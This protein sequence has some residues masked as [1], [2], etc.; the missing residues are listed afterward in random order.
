MSLVHDR[1]LD[2]LRSSP[3][4][5][6]HTRAKYVYRKLEHIAALKIQLSQYSFKK[7]RHISTNLLVFLGRVVERVSHFRTPR[8]F[9]PPHVCRGSCCAGAWNLGQGTAPPPQTTRACRGSTLRVSPGVLNASTKSCCVWPRGYGR[10]QYLHRGDTRR[11]RW[12]S[13]NNALSTGG[14][15]DMFH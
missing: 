4:W 10:R 14:S 13:N 7:K 8:N 9:P 2:L 12:D 1:S 6:R 5:M 11:R 3:L 15:S